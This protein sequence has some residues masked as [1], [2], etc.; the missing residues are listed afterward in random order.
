MIA[1]IADVPNDGLRFSFQ[2]VSLT[3]GTPDGTVDQS[4][5]I[6][7]GALVV[8]WNDPGA[9]DASRSVTRGDLLAMVCDIETFTAGDS[10]TIQ[11]GIVSGFNALSMPYGI[12]VVTTKGVLVIPQFF[13]HYT[14]SGGFWHM[15]HPLCFTHVSNT[16]LSFDTGTTPDEAA[17]LFQVPFPCKLNEVAAWLS[18][19]AAGSDFDC[20]LYDASNNILATLSYDGDVEAGGTSTRFWTF[21][22]QT[23]VTLSANT[24]YRLSFLPTTTVNITLFYATYPDAD[25]MGAMPGGTNFCL[26]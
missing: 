3:D 24:N 12:S 21:F 14:D 25:L 5:K 7:S 11:A 1:A 8:G 23:E 22:P 13:L 9:F 10:I 19:T 4:A 2:N 6:A 18:M 17:L 20:I 15:V 26:S 16:Q